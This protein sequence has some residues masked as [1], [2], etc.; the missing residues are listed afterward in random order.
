MQKEDLLE[1][2]ILQGT[3]PY[4]PQNTVLRYVAVMRLLPPSQLLRNVVKKGRGART[5]NPERPAEAQLP[6]QFHG[7]NMTAI[8]LM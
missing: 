5:Q 2:S 8:M 1:K 3:C 6:I 4:L 7:A